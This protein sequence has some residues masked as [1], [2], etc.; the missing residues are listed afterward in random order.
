MADDFIEK[1]CIEK[2]KTINEKM[3][4][5]SLNIDKVA[6]MTRVSVSGL[7]K[8]INGFYVVA[9]ATLAATLFDIIK[10]MVLK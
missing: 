7:H 3:E 8:K 5:M 4:K 2:H 9:I 6:E 10:Y 1:L